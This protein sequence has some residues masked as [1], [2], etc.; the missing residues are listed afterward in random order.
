M[1]VTDTGFS[2][3]LVVGILV[4]ALVLLAAGLVIYNILKITVSRRIRQYG[5]LR[6]IGA[7]KGHLIFYT[8]PS[9]LARKYH[10]MLK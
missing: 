8:Q 4:A 10:N 6:A 2:F 9:P 1:D 7:E 5:E 3:M